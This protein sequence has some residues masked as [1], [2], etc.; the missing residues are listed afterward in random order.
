MPQMGIRTQRHHT[1]YNAAGCFC[2][3]YLQEVRSQDRA[4]CES[5]QC[6]I[7]KT[8]VAEVAQTDLGYAPFSV[9]RQDE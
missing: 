7:H 3:V 2:E 1:N 6:G 8:R 5:L 4:V 9:E